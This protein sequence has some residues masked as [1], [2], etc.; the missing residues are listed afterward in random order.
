V[1]KFAFNL[2]TLL[3]HR[4]NLEERERELLGAIY[5]RLQVEIGRMD[6]LRAKHAEVRSQLSRQELREYD[7]REIGWY[8]TFLRRLD[9]E[10]EQ[11]ARR[12]QNL[13]QELEAQMVAWI[14]RS[15]DKKVLENLRQRKERDYRKAMDRIEQKD[16]DELVVTRYAREK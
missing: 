12:I 13:R 16:I 5:N 6:R 4:T 9:H 11:T 15:K 14:E 2:E 10:M 3:R 7:A 8:C 1:R